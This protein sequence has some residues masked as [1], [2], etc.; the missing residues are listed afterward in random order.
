[1]RIGLLGG[2]FDPPH[3]GHLHLARIASQALDLDSILFIPCY[4]Q[5]LK[6]EAPHASGFHRAAMV[7]L[8][9]SG[10][11]R[12]LLESLELERGDVSYT[13]DTVEALGTRFPGTRLILLLGDDALAAFP[14]WHRFRDILAAADLAVVPRGGA[15]SVP[16]PRSLPSSRVHLLNGEP[17]EV[18]STL[19]RQ[20]VAAGRSAGHM[21]P[22]RV[23]AYIRKE[24]LY[25]G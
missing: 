14:R 24:G 13:A 22:R 9:L 11:R 4:R 10:H 3:N 8:A 16:V 20:T 5:P 15:D 1:M 19:I 6:T 18:S 17:L 21:T 23:A 7:A 2:S 25:R 12:W